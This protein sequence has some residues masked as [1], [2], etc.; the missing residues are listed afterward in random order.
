MNCN[1][2]IFDSDWNLDEKN[3]EKFVTPG[4]HALLFKKTPFFLFFESIRAAFLLSFSLSFFL[5]SSNCNGYV[6][7]QGRLMNRASSDRRQ[8]LFYWLSISA[9]AARMH[10]PQL[11]TFIT[12]ST[13]RIHPS[14][15]FV[16]AS[17][18]I[19][20]HLF[21]SSMH[22]I[23]PIGSLP[24]NR[25]LWAHSLQWCLA[26]FQGDSKSRPCHLRRCDINPLR[27]L[28]SISKRVSGVH[29]PI[30]SSSSTP[31]SFV[32]TMASITTI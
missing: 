30:I 16:Q 31:L 19:P 11:P 13:N 2:I 23:H 25:S 1:K 32:Y 21:R 18:V 26:T 8:F 5:P 15:H 9:D 10:P 20:V 29:V 22:G 4:E 14:Q 27:R 28:W 24:C 7:L 3:R 12:S 17:H 6:A